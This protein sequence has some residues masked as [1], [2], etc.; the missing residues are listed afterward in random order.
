[1]GEWEMPPGARAPPRKPKAPVVGVN[2]PGMV[3]V[4]A[5]CGVDSARAH[6]YSKEPSRSWKGVGK[7]FR[8]FHLDQ[9]VSTALGGSLQ[10]GSGRG[11]L[12]R[13]CLSE[14][15]RKGSSSIWEEWAA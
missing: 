8:G 2:A 7:N 9:G 10:W 3:T 1:M 11:L 14:A 15:G 5:R 13:R 12:L 4:G 6:R